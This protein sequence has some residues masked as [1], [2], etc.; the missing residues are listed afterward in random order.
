MIANNAHIS[1]M[2]IQCPSPLCVYFFCV[3]FTG[4]AARR[5]GV[6]KFVKNL[7]GHTSK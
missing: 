3:A 1:R 2:H 4:K 5:F 6:D 7:I